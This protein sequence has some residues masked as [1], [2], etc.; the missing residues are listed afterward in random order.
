MSDAVAKEGI[1]RRRG[2]SKTRKRRKSKKS[3]EGGLEDEGEGEGELGH[4][5]GWSK[6]NTFVYMLVRVGEYHTMKCNTT[7]RQFAKS[8][9]RFGA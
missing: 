1:R 4:Q 5:S 7:F 8:L 9:V 3:M 2:K 6:T